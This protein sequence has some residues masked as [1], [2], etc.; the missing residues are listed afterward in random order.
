MG[1]PAGD[2]LPDC[3]GEPDGDPLPGDGEPDIGLPEPPVGGGG[4]WGG[5]LRNSRIAISTA[6]AASSN[7]NSQDTRMVRQPARS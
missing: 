2:P 6:S 4:D 1:E 3:D 7:I 5:W